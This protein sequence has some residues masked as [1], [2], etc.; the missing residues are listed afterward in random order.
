M[1]HGLVGKCLGWT[2]SAGLD[3]FHID[4]GHR[5]DESSIQV[6]REHLLQYVQEWIALTPIQTRFDSEDWMW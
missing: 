2:Y 6:S 3:P 1:R 5:W 4:T